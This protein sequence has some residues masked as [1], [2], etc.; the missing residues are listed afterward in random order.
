[1][2]KLY[3]SHIHR[4]FVWVFETLKLSQK[5]FGEKIGLSQIVKALLEDSQRRVSLV[6]LFNIT[7]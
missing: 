7:A 6:A 1:M 5:D 3:H 4:R 2:K